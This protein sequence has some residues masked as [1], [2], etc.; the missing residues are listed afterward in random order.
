VDALRQIASQV[1]QFSEV[2]S[3]PDMKNFQLLMR[4]M[5]FRAL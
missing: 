1:S 4:M 3:S 2:G 5:L